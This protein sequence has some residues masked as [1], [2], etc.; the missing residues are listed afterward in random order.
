MWVNVCDFG[1]VIDTFWKWQ[2][3]VGVWVEEGF[4]LSA[5]KQKK[6]HTHIRM[7]VTKK[8]RKRGHHSLVL[9][10]IPLLGEGVELSRRT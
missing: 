3:C 9:A 1:G 6:T 8:G 5:L 7:N 10:Y 4:V 2:G